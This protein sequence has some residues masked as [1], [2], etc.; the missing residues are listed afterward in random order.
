MPPPIDC[1][2][3]RGEIVLDAMDTTPDGSDDENFRLA[4]VAA[5]AAGIVIEDDD[6]LPMAGNVTVVADVVDNDAEFV[7]EFA[8]EALLDE[9]PPPHPAKAI[10]KTAPAI[11]ED[12]RSKREFKRA[13]CVKVPRIVCRGGT[14]AWPPFGVPP[15]E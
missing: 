14:G 7:T 2:C 4:L 9:P 15:S 8:L 3:E 1:T 13:P 11:T 5:L 10:A 12:K 6:T